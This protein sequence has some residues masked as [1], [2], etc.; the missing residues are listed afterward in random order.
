MPPVNSNATTLG[1]SDMASPAVFTT[2]TKLTAING[3]KL[4]APTA[5]ATAMGDSVRSAIRGIEDGGVV[6]CAG[7][8]SPSGGGVLNSNGTTIS[9]AG[10]TIA[11][12]ISISGPNQEAPTGDAT[13]LTSDARE[14]VRGIEDGGSLD[15]EANLL[16]TDTTGQDVVA[17]RAQS[18]ASSAFVITFADSTTCSFTAFVTGYELMAKVDDAMRVKFSLKV[19]GAVTSPSLA[20]G[21]AAIVTAMAS[22]TLTDF[23]ITLPSTLGNITYSA[24]V[25]RLSYEVALDQPVGLAFAM[26]VSGS[27]VLSYI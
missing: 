16:T 10:N 19:D 11:Q 21:Q 7:F 5:D 4:Q 15:I 14:F 18:G 8:M 1:I 27:P 26:K 25:T 13:H 12:V 6:D 20:T 22:G 24:Y 23:K 17:T 3:V 9:I 2:I